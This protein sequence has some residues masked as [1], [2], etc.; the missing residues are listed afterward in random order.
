MHHAKTWRVTVRHLVHLII[1]WT[2]PRSPSSESKS[3][4]SG[5]RETKD[6]CRKLE[7]Q[8]CPLKWGE[9]G[10]SEVSPAWRVSQQALIL[11]QPVL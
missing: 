5:E 9:G 7:I 3:E 8:T 4:N 2:D 6:D 11:V 1:S 10:Y